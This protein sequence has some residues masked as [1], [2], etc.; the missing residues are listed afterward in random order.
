MK[1]RM[2]IN[3]SLERI[4]TLFSE[5]MKTDNIELSRRYIKIMEKIGMRMNITVDK[6]IKR[7]YCKICKTPYRNISVKVK[8]KM[9]LIHCPYCGNIRRIPLDKEEK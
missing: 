9:V 2:L 4:N 1:D 8:N 5:A 7:M 6:N 3:I